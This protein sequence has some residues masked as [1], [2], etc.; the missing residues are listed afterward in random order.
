MEEKT[1]S[2]NVQKTPLELT[3]VLNAFVVEHYVFGMNGYRNGVKSD[4]NRWLQF[5]K[6]KINGERPFRGSEM[7]GKTR[8]LGLRSVLNGFH[9]G[10]LRLI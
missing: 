2:K 6:I 8:L 10:R 5:K 7:S 1:L 3:G 4:I 9:S